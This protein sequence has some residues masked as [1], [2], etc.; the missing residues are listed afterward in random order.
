ML[1]RQLALQKD[2]EKTVWGGESAID[3]TIWRK[4]WMQPK[5][6]VRATRAPPR[7]RLC[8]PGKRTWPENKSKPNLIPAPS[9]SGGSQ[10]ASVFFLSL[11]LPLR[12]GRALPAAQFGPAQVSTELRIHHSRP[13]RGLMEEQGD[14]SGGVQLSLRRV[15]GQVTGGKLAKRRL[16]RWKQ[17]FSAPQA[18]RQMSPPGTGSSRQQPPQMSLFPALKNGIFLSGSLGKSYWVFL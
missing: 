8:L 16:S 15:R 5:I 13:Q 1:A 12:S 10:Q 3:T 7:A 18:A 14:S 6:C 11:S 4:K 17:L 9:A 2:R